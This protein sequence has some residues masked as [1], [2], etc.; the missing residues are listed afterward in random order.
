MMLE[1]DLT[2]GAN[3]L[4]GIPRRRCLVWLVNVGRQVLSQNQENREFNGLQSCR[5]KPTLRW[6]YEDGQRIIIL[7]SME[8]MKGNE[9]PLVIC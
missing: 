8:S 2:E 9:G 4:G 5:Y 3:T 7:I 1:N 6:K